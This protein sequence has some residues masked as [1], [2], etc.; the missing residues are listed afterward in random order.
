MTIVQKLGFSPAKKVFAYGSGDRNDRARSGNRTHFG[1]IFFQ[2]DALSV[3]F[4]E[5]YQSFYMAQLCVMIRLSV[6]VS[7]LVSPVLF[8]PRAPLQEDSSDVSC[9]WCPQIGVPVTPVSAPCWHGC[10]VVVLLSTNR[11][12]R[13]Y[14]VFFHC[15]YCLHF[16][17]QRMVFGCRFRMQ[18]QKSATKTTILLLIFLCRARFMQRSCSWT[19]NSTNIAIYVAVFQKRRNNMQQLRL[20]KGSAWKIPGFVC[21]ISDQY[22]RLTLQ[23]GG[24]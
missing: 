9:C 7:V 13:N 21:L 19:I 12:F 16:G 17:V 11:V 23:S 5:A 10:N 18:K 6:L 15:F 1:S 8:L 3:H 2:I 20:G 4:D 24:N 14:V 22:P